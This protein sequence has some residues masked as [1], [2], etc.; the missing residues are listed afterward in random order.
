MSIY[1]NGAAVEMYDSKVKDAYQGKGML[2]GFTDIRTGVEGTSYNFALRGT[3]EAQQ[4]GAAASILP[5]VNPQYS[6]PTAILNDWVWP[7]PTDIF[8]QKQVNFDEISSLA[9]SQTKALGRRTDKI[10]INAAV[11]SGTT[12]IINNTGTNLSVENLREVLAYFDGLGVP[13]EECTLAISAKGLQSLLRDE[14]VTSQ[15]YNSVQPLA[16]GTLRKYLGMN[17]IVL[18]NNTGLPDDG[19]GFSGSL[20]KTGNIVT[21]YAFHREAIGYAEASI[22]S[23]VDY[24]PER[25]SYISMAAIRAGAVAV[26]NTGIVSIQYDESVGG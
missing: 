12:N 8:Q 4:R 23:R 26:D 7:T 6:R 9:N 16:T 14:Q 22:E 25:A 13:Y 10:I 20:P 21:A 19:S 1:L 18:P 2:K 11:L 5:F 15:L 17:I 24:S 3:A